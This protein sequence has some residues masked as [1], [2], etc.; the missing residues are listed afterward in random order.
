M[1][2]ALF[3]F[4]DW[5]NIS[6]CVVSDVELDCSTARD[7]D[8][9]GGNGCGVFLKDISSFGPMFNSMGGGWYDETIC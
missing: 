9:Q 4:N 5:V 8:C 7:T 1:Y 6:H 2:D 3:P